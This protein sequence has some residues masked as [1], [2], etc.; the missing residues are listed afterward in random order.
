MSLKAD[1]MM[2]RIES[3]NQPE[4]GT[5]GAALLAGFASG[6]FDDLEQALKIFTEV[7]RRYEPDPNRA[8]LYRGRIQFYRSILTDLLHV[9]WNEVLF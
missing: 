9:D 7:S 1:L 3:V 4:P 8:D 2:T 5:L 6:F